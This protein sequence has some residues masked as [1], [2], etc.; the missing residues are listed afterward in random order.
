MPNCV[1]EFYEGEIFKI[2]TSH[3]S[4]A[5]KAVVL[6]GTMVSQ[7]AASTAE[8]SCRQNP[9][10]IGAVV[11]IITVLKELACKRRASSRQMGELNRDDSSW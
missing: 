1:R 8:I 9:F 5:G 6:R 3:A 7:S 10:V 4:S 11:C 2:Y